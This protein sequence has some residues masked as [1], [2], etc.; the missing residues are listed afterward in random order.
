MQRDSGQA[1]QTQ[2]VERSPST[3][4]VTATR[5]QS[6][7]D[8]RIVFVSSDCAGRKHELSGRGRGYQETVQ[9]IVFKGIRTLRT[10]VWCC[11]VLGVS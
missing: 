4:M 3:E 8:T 6:S 1:E 9:L 5:C 11:I 10:T 7:H 2:E